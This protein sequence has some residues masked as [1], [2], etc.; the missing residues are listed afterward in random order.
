MKNFKQLLK[1]LPSNKV[2]LAF[3]QFSP[4]TSGHELIVKSVKK[5]SESQSSDHVV[6][7][8][9]DLKETLLS[10]DKKVHY[11]GI[12]FPG[13]NV[14]STD[15]TLVETVKE[16][17]KKYKN[18]VMVAPSDCKEDY[19]K[20]LT[21]KNNKEFFFETIEVVSTG[22]VNPDKNQL[23]ESVKKGNYDKFK[24]YLPT[25]LREI[26]SRRLMN[27]M[28]KSLGLDILKEEIKFVK[29]ELREQYFRGDIF[30][31]GDVVTANE[32]HYTIVKRGTNHLLLKEQTGKLVSKWIQDVTEATLDE[33]LSKDA[34]A[35]DWIHDFIHSDNPKF[36]GKSKKER[37]KMALGAYYAKQKA[38]V[39]EELTNKTLRPADKLKV[40]RI[41]A[42]MLGVEK[43]ES[44]ANPENMVNAA[45]R[46]IR[47]KA[48]NAE[49]YKV[50]DNMLALATEV[51]IQ[52]DTALKPARLKEESTPEETNEKNLED[53][54]ESQLDLTDEQI[55]QL[56]E[57]MPE[58]DIINEYDE[59]EFYCVDDETGEEV[60]ESEF[61]T[62][63]D[64]QILEVL[65]RSER[66]RAKA[67]F[68][69]TKSKRMN[70]T[71][72]AL[73]TRAPQKKINQRARRLAI[74][75]I[76][77]RMLRGRNYAKISIGE[78]ERIE[79]ILKK[80]KDTIKRVAMKLVPRIRNV[81]KSRLKHQK[82]KPSGGAGNVTF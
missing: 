36:A 3:G 75:L 8:T 50:L 9:D 65:S 20:L 71:R 34:K 41:I 38:P 35:G 19:Q 48:L 51:G 49:G 10:S 21:S 59:D 42:T 45:L 69:R 77:K 7:A 5:I 15:K 47:S 54:L 13:I 57:E 23:K 37:M 44:S 1:E 43:V 70:K 6:Y 40:A 11:M 52:Y 63:E 66:M 14:Q 72:I 4:P 56:I 55:D 22:D 32:Q 39:S 68:A 25:S 82:Y 61:M 26:D 16:L 73:R 53:Q 2:V 33:V 74:K 67:R 29:D 31:V 17:N 46:K 60:P 76:K 80:R 78:K 58:D 24:K 64:Y 28:R 27:D 79:R 62:N 81:E 30:N 18:L 12:M